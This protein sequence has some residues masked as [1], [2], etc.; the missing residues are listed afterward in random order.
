M[1]PPLA[2]SAPDIRPL[3]EDELPMVT[4]LY[5]A[6]F[7]APPWND[8]WTPETAASRLRDA[9]RTPGALGMVVWQDGQLVACLLGYREQWHD[10]IH[11]Y[12]KELFVEAARQRRGIGMQLLQELT[13]RLHG[14]QVSRIY[15]LTERG[16]D[17]ADFYLAQGYYQSPR[18]TMMVTRLEDA[19]DRPGR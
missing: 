4:A 2:G 10:G 15:L 11:F 18:M 9:A 16:G 6:V 7:N 8:A 19:Q 3:T 1:N 5:C 12:L 13:R 14:D 17:A